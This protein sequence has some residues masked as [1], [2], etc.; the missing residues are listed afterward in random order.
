MAAGEL[1]Y[2]ISST[3]STGASANVIA[4]QACREVFLNSAFSQV[5]GSLEKQNI[6]QQMLAK[7]RNIFTEIYLIL[8]WGFLFSFALTPIVNHF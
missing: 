6:P 4:C 3:L 2:V 5:F 7:K 8:R 1:K